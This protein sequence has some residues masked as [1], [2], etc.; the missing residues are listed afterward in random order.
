MNEPA[1]ILMVA[2]FLWAGWTDFK[3]R[4]VDDFVSI[5]AWLVAW[6]YFDPNVLV[7]SFI[8]A[9]LAADIVSRLE[10]YARRRLRKNAKQIEVFGWADI[11]MV[12]PF[13]AAVANWYSFQTA[14]VVIGL[15]LLG[16][17]VWQYKTKIGAPLV[18][19]MA[20]GFFLILFYQT[21]FAQPPNM[22]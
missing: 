11:L 18:T 14:G 12:P 6:L 3:R 4:E 10:N 19:S 16:T 1:L 9:W 20:I 21:V 22:L 17:L 5:A 7:L 8:L 2:I 13:V 15:I